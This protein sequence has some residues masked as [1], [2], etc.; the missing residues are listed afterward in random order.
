MSTSESTRFVDIHR[1][2]KLADVQGQSKAVAQLT[3][4]LQSGKVTGNTLLISGPYGTGKTSIGRILARTVNCSKGGIDPCEECASC[5]LTVKNHPDIKELDAAESRGIDDVRQLMD[6]AKLSPRYKARVFVIDEAHQFTGPAAQALLKTLEE[7][8]KHAS[9]ILC[10]TDPYKLPQAIRS[11]SAWVKLA[12][13]PQRDVARLLLKICKSE[14]LNYPK[15][16]LLYIAETAGGHA[17]DAVTML[18]QLG[19]ASTTMSLDEAKEALPEIVEGILGSSPDA[20]VPK[21][22]H[23]LLDGT[24]HSMVYLRK[25][26]NPEYLLSLILKFLKELT[27]YYIEPK[28][29]D[30][31]ALASFVKATQFKKKITSDVLTSILEIH[32]DAQERVKT[33]STDPMDALDLAILK[34][35]KVLGG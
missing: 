32:M 5:R 34:S 26:E 12:E 15:E 23:K 21:Y 3:G 25:V 13:L 33:R 24:I 19:S 1:P 2:Q 14:G 4:L 35:V 30:N 18:E 31:N 17:R 7:P 27:I 28:M 22:V 20:L 29:V 10:T 9:F 11:R 6:V 16:V 8:P